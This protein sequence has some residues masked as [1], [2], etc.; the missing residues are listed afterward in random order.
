MTLVVV[1]INQRD[2]DGIAAGCPF[3]DPNL[4]IGVSRFC[5]HASVSPTGIAWRK[6]KSILGRVDVGTGSDVRVWF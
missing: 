2:F 3:L 4:Q 1:F 5:V 6:Q